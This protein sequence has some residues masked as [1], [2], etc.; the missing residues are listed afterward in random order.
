MNS[1]PASGD[2]PEPSRTS[3]GAVEMIRSEERLRTSTVRR[4]ATRV[5]LRKRI[6]TETRTITVQ[7]SREEFVQ[8]QE[9]ITGPGG[10]Q[11]GQLLGESDALDIEFVLHEQ[12]PVVSMETVAVERVRVRTR[13]ITEDQTITDTVRKEQIELH[14][15]PTHRSAD[16]QTTHQSVTPTSPERYSS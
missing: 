16:V 9:S 2:L 3:P 7:V 12:R 8:E 5:R 10:D 6:V 14:H 1:V 4:P 13:T 15:E 11:S